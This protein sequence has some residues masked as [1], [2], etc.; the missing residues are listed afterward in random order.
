MLSV[1]WVVMAGSAPDAREA[2]AATADDV[3]AVLREAL[4]ALPPETSGA[5][6][7][8]LTAELPEALRTEGRWTYARGPVLVTVTVTDPPGGDGP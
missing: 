2:Q 3:P 1:S 8:A 6:R 4:A 7:L 5:V